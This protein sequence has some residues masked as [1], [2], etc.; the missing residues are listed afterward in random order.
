MFLSEIRDA[1]S[2]GKDGLDVKGAFGVLG[3]AFLGSKRALRTRHPSIKI[4]AQTSILSQTSIKIGALG[5]QNERF[6]PGI[7]HNRGFRVLVSSVSLKTFF[8]FGV[9][10]FSFWIKICVL[11]HRSCIS[12]ASIPTLVLLLRVKVVVL[13]VLVEAV[14]LLPLM[15]PSLLAAVSPHAKLLLLFLV[16][17]QAATL[18]YML[19]IQFGTVCIRRR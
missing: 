17:V 5:G 11:Q 12:T 8:T 14:V 10:G 9:L 7:L 19:L 16:T 2:V 4:G 15:L 1:L 18:A 13:V 3:C 6:A